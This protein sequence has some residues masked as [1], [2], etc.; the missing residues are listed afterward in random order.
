MI[1]SLQI[2]QP[3]TLNRNFKDF[4]YLPSNCNSWSHKIQNNSCKIKHKCLAV[5]CTH[6]TLIAVP[7]NIHF[8]WNFISE[9]KIWTEHVLFWNFWK[10]LSFDA[11]FSD[12]MFTFSNFPAISR[13]VQLFFR[14]KG[15]FISPKK[16][17]IFKLQ[18]I[19]Q[20]FFKF[21]CFQKLNSEF[22]NCHFSNNFMIWSVST[23][24]DLISN[25]FS[26]TPAS[27]FARAPQ[28]IGSSWKSWPSKSETKLK[29]LLG[30]TKWSR[31]S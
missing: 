26:C 7:R 4:P 27:S 25:H 29:I 8:W 28:N 30:N 9:F 1:N 18:L 21:C 2:R 6:V 23:Q 20:S 31:K 5:T 14:Q 17:Q 24:L 3:W 10:F 19:K 22:L 15:S 12:F 16:S 11:R 13:F